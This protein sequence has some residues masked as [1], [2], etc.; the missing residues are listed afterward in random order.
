MLAHINNDDLNSITN[1]AKTI[2]SKTNHKITDWWSFI[3]NIEFLILVG[4]YEDAKDELNNHFDQL[5]KDE[6]TEFNISSTIRQLNLYNKYFCKDSVLKEMIDF[7][8]NIN[9]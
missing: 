3:S 1:E 5:D 2:W 4:Q 6:I 8:N 9:H 7:I